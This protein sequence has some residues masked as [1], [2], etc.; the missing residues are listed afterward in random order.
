[1]QG[2]A[3]PNEEASPKKKSP[4]LSAPGH[5]IIQGHFGSPHFVQNPEK[6]RAALYISQ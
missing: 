3:F 4:R 6:T 5:T 1:M 2:K